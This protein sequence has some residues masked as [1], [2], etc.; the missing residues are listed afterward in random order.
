MKLSEK[1]VTVVTKQDES[2]NNTVIHMPS[3]NSPALPRA[4]LIFACDATQSRE[5][6]WQIAR[7]VQADMF[8]AATPIGALDVQLVFFRG[9][10]LGMTKWVSSGE[11]IA[12]T[13]CKIECIA[14]LTQI[15][16]V[17]QHVLDEHAKAPV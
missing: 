17:L 7:R 6:T 12:Q 9:T 11:Q 1:V 4:R 14:G 5:A 3:G 13:M 8:R 16:R 15:E 2:V 10:K